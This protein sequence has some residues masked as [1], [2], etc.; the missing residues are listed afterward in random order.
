MLLQAFKILLKDF[1]LRAIQ[2]SLFQVQIKNSRYG[3]K[4]K[5]RNKMNSS[6]YGVDEDLIRIE[7]F[8]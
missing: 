3:D 8:S 7:S 6:V 4:D 5:T 1:S 2:T